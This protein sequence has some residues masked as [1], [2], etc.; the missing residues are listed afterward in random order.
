MYNKKKKIIKWSIQYAQSDEICNKFCAICAF[1]AS[2]CASD[3]PD[4]IE[5][6]KD[7]LIQETEELGTKLQLYL[8]KQATIEHVPFF[9]AAAGVAERLRGDQSGNAVAIRWR[10]C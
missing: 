10:E 1:F 8:K 5:R 3:F 7:K 6:Q 9:A 2:A 4:M